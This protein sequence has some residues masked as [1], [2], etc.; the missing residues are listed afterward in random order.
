MQNK[1]TGDIGDFAKYGLLRAL[2]KGKRL[3]IAW[4]LYPDEKHNK[5]GRHVEYLEKPDVWRSLDRDVF[6]V[7]GRIVDEDKRCIAR[8]S[9]A[10]VEASGL[11]PEAKFANERLDTDIPPSAWARRK[12]WR[13]G[14]FERVRKTLSGC[15]IVF[16]DP[17]NGL[18]L[19]E[20][21]SPSR[22]TDWKS[23]PLGEALKLSAD[24]PAI[25]YHHNT[26]WK[27]DVEI[28]YWMRR[29]PGCTS[30]F[31]CRR[32]TNR[33]FFVLNADDSIIGNL[34]EFV[35]KWQEAERKDGLKSDKLSKL[36]T[37]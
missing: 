4:Y 25:L 9:V 32:Y 1:Y 30:A 15:Q 11:L 5:D 6:E 36:I 13:F 12:E 24:C 14:W 16:A 26:R 21:Y 34:T 2:S 28:R 37:V 35:E 10:V 29:L 17:D 3:G 33:T 19:D 27:H 18:C 7:L 23:L 22:R 31:Y 8:R 20:K